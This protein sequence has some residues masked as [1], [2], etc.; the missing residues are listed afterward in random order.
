MADHDFLN[1]YEDIEKHG[2]ELPH[3][4]QGESMQFVTFRLGDS[5]PKEKV[6]LWL[7]ERK[8][9]LVRQ[10]PP[11][12][13]ATAREY[14]QRFTRKLEKWLDDCEGSCL[15]RNRSDR[16]ILERTMMRFQG[17]RYELI[18]RVIMPNHVHA[19][20]I[21]KEKI[22]KTIQ[23]WKAFSARGIGK[24]SIWQRDYRDTLI[25]DSEHFRNA[26]RYIRRNPSK[27][28]LRPDEFSLW[29][30]PRAAAIE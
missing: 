11:W 9:F 14:Q 1:P 20:F 15:L 3:W 16:E 5:I 22:E 18:S 4:Q 29:E 8:M 2:R 13:E 26:V 19:I 17:I 23:A 7:A 27:A 10:P 30:S 28:R 25:R 12:N 24:G 6:D 21:P